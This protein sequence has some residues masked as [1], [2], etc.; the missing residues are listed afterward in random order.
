LRLLK[1]RGG[2]AANELAD[3]LAASLSIQHG[4]KAE[5]DTAAELANGILAMTLTE[6]PDVRM[7][8]PDSDDGSDTDEEELP[9]VEEDQPRIAMED[10]VVIAND[11]DDPA[12]ISPFSEPAPELGFAVDSAR[13]QALKWQEIEDAFYRKLAEVGYRP[14]IEMSLDNTPHIDDTPATVY[15]V[16]LWDKL[17]QL[18]RE[19]G[20]C[21]KVSITPI[22]QKITSL[23]TTVSIE[24]VDTCWD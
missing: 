14:R 13:E 7:E 4:S 11:D 8:Y 23:R 9:D 1:A 3:R 5:N 22:P 6:R 10:M 21:P 20:A 16:G 19:F 18:A 24:S 17:V 12:P 15:V 2:D